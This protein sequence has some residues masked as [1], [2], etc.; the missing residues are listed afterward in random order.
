[1]RPTQDLN[2]QCQ[3]GKAFSN[4]PFPTCC[5]ILTF[6]LHEMTPSRSQTELEDLFGTLN[7]K[8]FS[9]LFINHLFKKYILLVAQIEQVKYGNTF[10]HSKLRNE[11][12]M[13]QMIPIHQTNQKIK[14]LIMLDIFRIP[15]YFIRKYFL[16]M[17]MN[18]NYVILMIQ[19]CNL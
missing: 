10:Y 13:T 16:L 18:S 4:F 7:K 9:N 15:L 8:K 1:M 5:I 6:Y 19:I 14:C 17:D 3:I 12:N 2:F 11:L